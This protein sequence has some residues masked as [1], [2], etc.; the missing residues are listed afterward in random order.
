MISRTISFRESLSCAL[1][2]LI[3]DLPPISSLLRF[4]SIQ[5]SQSIL[6]VR[7][8]GEESYRNAV[9]LA[10]TI[11]QSGYQ[12]KILSYWS[13]NE[14]KN[15]NSGWAMPP[16][17]RG[18]IADAPRLSDF[19]FC[20]IYGYRLNLPRLMSHSYSVGELRP[21][22]LL[23]ESPWAQHLRGVAHCFNLM[24]AALNPAYVLVPNGAEV[25]SAIIT[26]VCS[27]ASTKFLYWESPFFQGHHFVDPYAPHFYC[28][29]SL[30]DKAWAQNTAEKFPLEKTR[31]FIKRFISEQ[32]S[33]YEQISKP[34]DVRR[35]ENWIA[36][37]TRPIVFIPQQIPT[38]AN[39][40]VNLGEYNDYEASLQAAIDSIPKDWRLLIKSHP[41][42][43]I[44]RPIQVRVQDSFDASG[45]AIHDILGRVS[46][47]ATM[48]SNV[49]LE[50]LLYNL[51]VVVWGKP[52]YSRK[53]CTTELNDPSSLGAY[54]SGPL[55]VVDELKRDAL[56]RH[57]LEIGLVRHR[58]SDRLCEILDL[59]TSTPRSFANFYPESIRRIS[60]AAGALAVEL[61]I[62]PRLEVALSKLNTANQDLIQ[63][64]AGPS[65]FE[66][67]YGGPIC[68]L[69][70]DVV[71]PNYHSL[72]SARI[73]RKLIRYSENLQNHHSPDNLL[74]CLCKRCSTS[75]FVALDVALPSGE[76]E[77][78]QGLNVDD[79]VSAINRIDPNIHI[80]V[81]AR[82][83]RRLIKSIADASDIFMLLRRKHRFLEQFISRLNS[84]RMR[85]VLSY[86]TALLGAAMFSTNCERSS[87]VVEILIS[88]PI[89]G[90]HVVYGPY[91]NLPAGKWRAQML[92]SSSGGI[93]ETEWTFDVV[94]NGKTVATVEWL[95]QGNGQPPAFSFENKVAGEIELRIWCHRLEKDEVF[96]F[97]GVE[98]H[99]LTGSSVV[100]SHN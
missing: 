48:S 85:S 97:R 100:T 90:S 68:S 70:A 65:L 40:V 20:S 29:E 35:L 61:K 86:E 44:R 53:G 59:A 46:V 32:K 13:D 72:F 67:R 69:K 96:V 95:S 84:R 87:D 23:P 43:G 30:I 64:V 42:G 79:I 57:V 24:L 51:P 75:H 21:D 74:R 12:P 27:R 28:G 37:D 33:K 15:T 89:R 49:G 60:N 81:R 58:D 14:H 25:I 80:E 7:T 45:I 16:L 71:R 19:A 10:L 56:I 3:R 73:A 17:L 82:D 88:G 92:L 2:V 54:L 94:V 5:M 8:T 83:G 6:I 52:V 4:Q 47:V 9:E 93:F 18:Q 41:K 50:A 98:L 62:E 91:R 31:A 66:H 36:A 77:Y 63:A 11:E 26:E 38:D 99:D 1:L 34:I 55:P 76:R 39:V 78:V 22:T